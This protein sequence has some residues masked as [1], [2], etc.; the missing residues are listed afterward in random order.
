MSESPFSS[1]LRVRI[2]DHD[3]QLTVRGDTHGEFQLNWALLAD[4]SK[5]F[6]ESVH[7]FIGA[8]NAL[9]LVNAEVQAP[10][11]PAWGAVPPVPPAPVAAPAAPRVP[12]SNPWSPPPAA[13]TVGPSPTCEHGQP[14]KLIP[15][16]ISKKTGKPY[17]G[18]YACASPDRNSQCKKTYPAS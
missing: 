8:V 13:E 11:E 10:Q 14:M 5:N 2:M 7:L 16:G 17:A 15:A 9:P 18:F 1:N 3:V 6:F 12:S 4:E